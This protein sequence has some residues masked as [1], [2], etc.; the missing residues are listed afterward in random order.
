MMNKTASILAH[1]MK[2]RSLNT[3]EAEP[4]GDHSLNSTV[5]TLA[6]E[7]GLNFVRVW[8]QVPNRFGSMT[9]VKR[10]SLPPS[11]LPRAK[12]VLDLMMKRSHK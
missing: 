4:L 11:E 2:P 5:S 9:R 10:Y 6:N 1:F 8:E 12:Q 3:F 7:Y